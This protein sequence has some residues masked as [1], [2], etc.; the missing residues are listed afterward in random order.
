ME[1]SFLSFEKRI[2]LVPAGGAILESASC[3]GLGLGCGL[4][5]WTLRP[6]KSDPTF[7]KMGS[8]PSYRNILRYLPIF[9]PWVRILNVRS[10]H[11]KRRT[12]YNID[13]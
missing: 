6:I 13:T 5:F 10:S 2:T 4:V 8:C 7:R 1:Q 9:F 12:F 11:Y 3:R